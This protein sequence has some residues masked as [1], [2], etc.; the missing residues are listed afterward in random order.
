[1]CRLVALLDM[2]ICLNSPGLFFILCL[3]M[4][5]SPIFWFEVSVTESGGI[6]GE[7]KALDSGAGLVVVRVLWSNWLD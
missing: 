6:G 5:F 3:L 2:L 1:M 7:R 4:V